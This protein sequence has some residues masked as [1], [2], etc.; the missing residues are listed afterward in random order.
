MILLTQVWSIWKS[1]TM[2]HLQRKK[3]FFLKIHPILCV[4]YF[5][6]Y[7]MF[8]FHSFK[9]I[10]NENVKPNCIFE[11]EKE[12][13]NKYKMNPPWNKTKIK[14]A[15]LFRFSDQKKKKKFLCWSHKFCVVVFLFYFYHIKRNI[16]KTKVHSFF[17][18]SFESF[19]T[20]PTLLYLICLYIQSVSLKK[21]AA[22]CIRESLRKNSHY[23]ACLS[24]HN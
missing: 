15:N 24:I 6:F 18:Q 20:P 9:N 19:S 1:L 23:N 17:T 11:D 12:K 7:F 14:R 16:P 22:K 5:Y 21:I 13:K 2:K 10:S 8:G 4:R 3:D